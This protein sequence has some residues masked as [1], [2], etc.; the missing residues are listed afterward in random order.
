MTTEA[1]QEFKTDKKPFWKDFVTMTDYFSHAILPLQSELGAASEDL[2]FNLGQ[3]LGEKA[4][5]QYRSLGLGET[6]EE[7]RRLWREKDIGRLEI[8]KKDPLE[9]VIYDCTVCGQLPGTGG[10]YDC[11]FHEGFFGGVISA[12]LNRKVTLSQVTNFEGSA[13]TWCRRYVTDVKL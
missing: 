7:L 10:M 8:E 4:A 3:V 12:K 11:A 2:F 5:Q 1:R 13:G 6:L 9:L